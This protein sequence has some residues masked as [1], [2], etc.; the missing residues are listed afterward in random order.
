MQC[1]RS[2][3][4]LRLDRAILIADEN[5]AILSEVSFEAALP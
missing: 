4:P 3:R 1:L 2:D 5:G